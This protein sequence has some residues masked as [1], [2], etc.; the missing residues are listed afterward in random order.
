MIS[1]EK[2]AEKYRDS[3]YSERNAEA[4][5]CQDIVLKAIEQS[6]FGRS[7]TIKGGVV[8]RSITG[9][10][11]SLPFRIY[12]SREKMRLS[13][14]FAIEKH[15]KISGKYKKYNFDTSG[16]TDDIDEKIKGD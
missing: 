4:R 14:F 1:L 12:C 13:I 15:E 8:M 11:T 9:I 3:G 10:N 16:Y 2:M 5:V 7:V 6:N